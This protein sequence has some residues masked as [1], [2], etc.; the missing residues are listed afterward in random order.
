[1]AN[2]WFKYYNAE[3][4]ELDLSKS[5][6]GKSITDRDIPEICELLDKFKIT[7]LS[8]ADSDISGEGIK[9]LAKNKT[10]TSLNVSGTFIGDE[11]AKALAKN[12]TIT[13]LNISENIIS[14]KGVK[15]LAKNKTIT[16]LNVSDNDIGIKGVKAL[17]KNKT[18]T[19]L[20]ISENAIGN[21]GAK[22]LAKNT[23]ITSLNVSDNDI[24]IKGAKALARNKT[25][26]SLDIS[27]NDIGDEGVKALVKNKTLT[28]LNVRWQG[29]DEDKIKKI[30]DAIERNKKIIKNIFVMQVITIAQ[31]AKQSQPN[32]CYFKYLS[33]ELLMR[34]FDYLSKDL[35][36]PSVL[37]CSLVLS[38][39]GIKPFRKGQERKQETHFAGTPIFKL[40]S[41]KNEAPSL[42]I[43][44]E[45]LRINHHP[46]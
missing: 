43:D 44:A 36:Q 11:D 34:I 25:L 19:S 24:G 5:R 32:N 7:S 20:D 31:G 6:L 28:S 29:I 45:K 18:L 42:P 1:M 26:T 40:F 23:T 17:A 4:S 13:S 30:Q 3:K 8:V 41:K 14:D 37:M 38:N 9:A 16:S 10:I 15:A 39:F 2:Q 12:K 46:M 22:S 21:K 27:D 33:S 35:N